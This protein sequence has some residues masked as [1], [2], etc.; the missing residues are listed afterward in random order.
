MNVSASSTPLTLRGI[1]APAGL[2]LA[3]PAILA[4]VPRSASGGVRAA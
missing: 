4:P 3:W 1:A 2:G